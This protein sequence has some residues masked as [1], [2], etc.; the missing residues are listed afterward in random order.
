MCQIWEIYQCEKFLNTWHSRGLL[1]QNNLSLAV[2][3]CCLACG[4]TKTC[5]LALKML[6]K[7]PAT[8]DNRGIDSNLSHLDLSWLDF[9][10][11][12][13]GKKLRLANYFLGDSFHHNP[14]ITHFEKFQ[15]IVQGGVCPY[16]MTTTNI[17]TFAIHS[18]EERESVFRNQ[19]EIACVKS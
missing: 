1:S 15:Y 14:D 3:P 12:T 16:Q 10:H 2:V 19:T 5:P 7:A 9:Q 6:C 18:V 13:G 8:E 17:S 4:A 11:S